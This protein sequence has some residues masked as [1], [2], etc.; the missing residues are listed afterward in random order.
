MWQ[1]IAIFALG[2]IL[3]AI[4]LVVVFRLPDP[5]P[6]QYTFLRIALAV[7]CS[8]IATALTGFLEVQ[9]QVP[10]LIKAGG[11]LAVFVIVYLFAPAAIK[12]ALTKDDF[13]VGDAIRVRQSGQQDIEIPDKGIIAWAPDMGR[14]RGQGGEIT[15]IE[16]RLDAVKVFRISVDNGQHAWHRDWLDRA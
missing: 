11:P 8:A 9:V 13:A 4:L 12:S 3:L 15:Q 16:T 2:A 1:P 5:T 14:F 10:V 7:A 6:F